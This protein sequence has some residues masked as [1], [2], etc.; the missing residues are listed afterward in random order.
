MS[1]KMT[2][3]EAIVA[4][5]GSKAELARLIKKDKAQVTR[6]KARGSVPWVYN[7]V[8]TRWAVLN[9]VADE[10]ATLLEPV[11]PCCGQGKVDLRA[12]EWYGAGE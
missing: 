12:T 3:L 8:L 5:V 9:D 11:C 10:M 4:L 2:N 6:F 7:E 1:T